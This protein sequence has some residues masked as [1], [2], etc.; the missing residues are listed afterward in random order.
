MA[1]LIVN[2]IGGGKHTYGITK[3]EADRL[4]A[5]GKAKM[6]F[7]G[8][9]YSESMT[10]Y[11]ETAAQAK[12]E[13]IAPPAFGTPRVEQIFSPDADD[14]REATDA[15]IEPPEP[16]KRKPGRPRKGE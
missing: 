7:R 11:P 5:E 2:T 4:V 13:S 9:Y 1:G 3:L 12:P 10:C 16:A 15:P 6:L 8:L 14:F